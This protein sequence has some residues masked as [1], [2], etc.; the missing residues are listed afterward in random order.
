MVVAGYDG[1]ALLDTLE[2]YDP[3]TGQWK[4]LTQTMAT[5]RCDAGVTVIRPV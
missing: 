3:N 2:Q 1:K 4:T 5:S